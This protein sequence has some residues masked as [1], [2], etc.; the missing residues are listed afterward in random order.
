ME[1]T[2]PTAPQS[3][4]RIRAHKTTSKQAREQAQQPH[5]DTTTHHDTASSSHETPRSYYPQPAHQPKPAAQ[6]SSSS[7]QPPDTQP[8]TQTTGRQDQPPAFV[9]KRRLR[10]GQPDRLPNPQ[11]ET[12][13]HGPTPALAT[14]LQDGRTI[15]RPPQPSPTP[16]E[17]PAQSSHATSHAA[18]PT[19][20][21]TTIKPTNHT[22]TTRRPPSPHAPAK[23]PLQLATR[24]TATGADS[25]TH[26]RQPNTQPHYNSC[27]NSPHRPAGR[28]AN[29]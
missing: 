26:R 10:E 3:I 21:A 12:A 7:D 15:G 18:I 22:T 2:S 14:R 25:T 20:T 27:R 13:R 6:A 17:Q 23:Q 19:A 9:D 24:G 11:P 28:H 5:T 29:R 1:L 8:G 16:S 4:L